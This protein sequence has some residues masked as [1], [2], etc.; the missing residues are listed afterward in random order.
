MKTTKNAMLLAGTVLTCLWGGSAQGMDSNVVRVDTRTGYGARVATSVEQVGEAD[1]SAIH[2]WDTTALEDGWTTLESGGNST[3]VCVLNTPEVVG[4]R[5]DAN[6]TWS[7]D[8]VRVVRDDVV[9]GEGATLTLERGCVVKFT[10]GAMIRLEEGGALLAK[11]AHLADVADD[12]VGGD[13]NLDGGGTF[14]G[15]LEW[16]REDETVGSLIGVDWVGG[17]DGLFKTTY[18][19]G[20]TYGELPEPEREDALFGGWFTQPGGAGVQ[21]TTETHV[22]P[23]VT[24]LYAKW[25]TL[26]VAVEPGRVEVEAMGGEY[27]V[28]VTANAAWTAETGVDWIH[29]GAESGD[30]DARLA[31]SVAANRT[32]A[33]RVAMVRVRL[34]RGG[35][36]RDI[37]VTQE[38]MERVAS[39]VIRPADGT[40]FKGT[41]Q[42]VVVSCATTGAQIY[43]T[44]DGSEPD[45]SGIPYTGSFNV[46]DTTTVKARAFKAGM[47]ESGT[48]SARLVRLR[49][50]A[51]AIDQ[52]LWEV[53]TDEE[54]PWTVTDGTTHD[55]EYAVRSGAIAD[56]E[57]T[58]METTV[59]GEGWLSF[60]WKTDCEDDPDGTG[61]DK[62]A[63]YLDGR[64]ISSID[65]SG[66]WQEVGVKIRGEGV[67]ELAWVY[68]KD[69]LNEGD[70]EDCGWVDQVTWSPTV[71]ETEVPVSWLSDLGLM[72]AGTTSAEAADADI[73]GD[74]FTAAQEYLAGTDPTDAG[75]FF[76]IDGIEVR[77]GQAELTWSPDLE[78]ERDYRVLGKKTM[79]DTEAWED[80][81]DKDRSE[82]RF[83]T[84]EIQSAGE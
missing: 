84:V 1:G 2:A 45:E 76:Q 54:H 75:S 18:S 65:G 78:G 7:A 50:L 25:T 68:S 24:A 55:G 60:W 19:A 8:R 37:T 13:T 47:L 64:L 4:G 23:Q 53:E 10:E 67:H 51:E 36:F 17:G 57:S 21:V 79:D 71:T 33:A 56:E 48:A 42:R 83:F 58:R 62:L 11:G 5:L 9:V 35:A 16:W 72:G 82:Y 44:L 80:V 31:L 69:W 29:L 27:E 73:D 61:W 46:F 49:T 43:C 77:E 28:D 66:E 32:T 15:A 40:T 39:P 14:P 59:E 20:E 26:S 63:F 30:G 52:P 74:G 12:S 22:M 81:T 41:A 38:G 34:V 70:R 3:E 6:A